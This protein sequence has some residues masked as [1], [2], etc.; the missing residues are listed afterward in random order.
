VLRRGA[1]EVKETNAELAAVLGIQPAAR[2]TCVKPDGNSS[3]YLDNSPPGVGDNHSRRFIRSAE[4]HQSCPIFQAFAAAN[5]HMVAPKMLPDG[6]V[7][8]QDAYVLFAVRP[9]AHGLFRSETT[10]LDFLARIRKVMRT[11]VEEGTA[12]EHPGIRIRHNVSNTVYVKDHEWDETAEYIFAHREDFG[13]L[14]VFS[15]WA[16]T[17]HPNAPYRAVD[18]PALSPEKR[19]ELEGLWTRLVEGGY[20]EV[21]YDAVIEAEDAT[22]QRAEAACAGGACDAV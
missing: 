19:A 3:V 15:D 17:A 6:R 14:T 21:D 11:W 4:A 8:D 13:G 10:A 20:N 2:A 18:N 9:P 7:S 12:R 16:E 22:T 5:P 1:Q